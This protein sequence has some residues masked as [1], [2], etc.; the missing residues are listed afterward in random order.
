M[1]QRSGKAAVGAIGL[2][3]ALSCAWPSLSL[4]G[5][6]PPAGF[7]P[8]T[9]WKSGAPPSS[10]AV[11]DWQAPAAPE[12]PPPA[13][14]PVELPV[15]AAPPPPGPPEEEV[16]TSEVV[17]EFIEDSGS[18]FMRWVSEAHLFSGYRWRRWN[19]RRW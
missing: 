15:E 14:D 6:D 9:R 3:L 5:G 17:G 11:A 7:A 19:G 4:A 16:A 8:W 12:P 10:A 18:D 2:A 13:P 1:E